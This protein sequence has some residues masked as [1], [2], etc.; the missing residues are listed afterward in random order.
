MTKLFTLAAILALLVCGQALG[1]DP[2]I[3]FTIELGGNN[4]GAN[5]PASF[6]AFTPGSDAD[7][8]TYAADFTWDV[9]VEMTSAITANGIANVVFD[10]EVHEGTAGGP[11]VDVTFYSTVNDGSSG[12]RPLKNA[13]FCSSMDVATNGANGGR[14]FDN[15]DSG[16]PYI[17]RVE[18][19]SSATYPAGSTASAGTL[20]GM[21]CGYSKYTPAG[22]YAAYEIYGY[23][24]TYSGGD[25]TA[26]LGLDFVAE[27]SW[28]PGT[29]YTYWPGLGLPGTGSLQ[30]PIAE[31]QI[32]M[33]DDANGVY[34]IVLVPGKCN[35]LK[36]DFDPE[37][38]DPGAFAVA[39][40]PQYV[41]GDTIE[42]VWE[43]GVSDEFDWGDAP[44]SYS[45]LNASAGPSHVITALTLGP[46]IDP[47]PDGQPSVG[48]VDDDNN[49]TGS[50][51]DED[52]VAIPVLRENRLDNIVVNASAPGLLDA[53]VDW[54]Q[55]GVFD[56]PAEHL[57]AGVSIAVVAGPNN[58]PVTPLPGDAGT[59]YARFRLS[60]AGGLPPTG[61]A[62]DGEVEDYEVVI[63]QESCPPPVLQTAESV[64]T[65]GAV[66]YGIAMNTN[67][68]AAVAEPRSQAGINFAPLKIEVTFDRP[69]Q[70]AD[71][72]LDIGD[73][74]VVTN[75]P[76]TAVSI[77]VAPNDNI[78]TIDLS[79]AVKNSCVSLTLHGIASVSDGTCA[80][81][82]PDSVMLDTTLYIRSVPGE[83][84]EPLLPVTIFDM[85]AV[86]AQLFRPIT[87]ANFK[88]DCFTDGVITIFDIGVP[89]ANLFGQAGCP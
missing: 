28:P 49:N 12:S 65:H 57:G 8:Q 39:V 53:W 33:S 31:G 32:N 15:C 36:N 44:D 23:D 45:T 17:D 27:G 80:V 50:P 6:P 34:V 43:G 46:T 64:M 3:Q 89:K 20:V 86:K 68:A 14:V 63:E 37:T 24:C 83:V 13:A 60:T 87:A 73:E 51:D 4:N 70:A 29:V 84:N 85:G 81:R 52:G 16:G 25:N 67:P 61:P 69:I 47:E 22:A 26:G 55:N 7:G 54:N 62:A 75:D 9:V 40:D 72:S 11:L 2:S 71:G 59:T 66:P 79:G 21:G 38:T 78:L 56:H 48:A 18:Y 42:F 30:K 10:L 76:V 88:L 41:Y 1:Q 82:D 5:P 35:V 19:P 74:V 58:V 77:G